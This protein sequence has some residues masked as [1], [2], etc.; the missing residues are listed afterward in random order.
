MNHGHEKAVFHGIVGTELN[1]KRKRATD[2]NKGLLQVPTWA[3]LSYVI[4]HKSSIK[5]LFTKWRQ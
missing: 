3:Y 5:A 2:K 1:S 4:P